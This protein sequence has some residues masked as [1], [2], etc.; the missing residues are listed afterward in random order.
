M[1]PAAMFGGLL[2]VAG[3]QQQHVHALPSHA[4][5]PAVAQLRGVGATPLHV[6]QTLRLRSSVGISKT[7]F[8]TS[9]QINSS[10]LSIEVLPK[11]VN[12]WEGAWAPGPLDPPMNG[13]IPSIKSGACCENSQCCSARS[14]L[15]TQPTPYLHAC[16]CTHSLTS[17]R[18]PRR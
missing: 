7:M 11:S 18:I 5:P 6:V 4:P 9:N 12:L 10:T 8:A 2:V 14:C 16:A 3:L 1:L 17:G 15:L 13:I